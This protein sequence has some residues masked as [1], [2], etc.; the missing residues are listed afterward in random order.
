MYRDFLLYLHQS[1]SPLDAV[2]Q[3][4]PLLRTKFDEHQPKVSR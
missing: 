3:D 2:C 1:H 4:R